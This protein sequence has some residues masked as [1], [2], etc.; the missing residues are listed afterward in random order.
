MKKKKKLRGPDSRQRWSCRRAW[1]C[2]VR[3]GLS[4]R[5]QA[6]QHRGGS[7]LGQLLVWCV[8]WVDSRR[9]MRPVSHLKIKKWANQDENLA[10]EHQTPRCICTAC[11]MLNSG[12]PL[13]SPSSGAAQGVSEKCWRTARLLL[14]GKKRIYMYNWI[15]FM[16]LWN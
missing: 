2:M 8:T 6:H 14:L 1:V 7:V 12:H 16:F 10:T 15:T 11:I 9:I 5:T 13:G 4:T 3:L